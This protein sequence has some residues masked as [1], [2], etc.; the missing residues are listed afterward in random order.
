MLNLIIQILILLFLKMSNSWIEK[1]RPKHLKNIIGQNNIIST[2]KNMI[3]NNYS[4]TNLLFYG[5]PGTG[6]TTTIL[7]LCYE[8]FGPINF[9]NRVLEL[10]AS[11]ERGIGVVRDSILRF[12]K[13]SLSSPDPNYPSP[14]IKLIILDEADAMTYDAQSALR[15]IMEDYLETTRFCIICNYIE[16]II[17][18]I[19]SRCMFFN[20]VP[21]DNKLIIRHLKKIAEKEKLKL[22]D[23]D[24]ENI[25]KSYNGD[26]R[27]A[28]SS[29][30]QLKYIDD[31]DLEDEIME[32]FNIEFYDN[33]YKKMQNMDMENKIKYFENNAFDKNK[34]RDYLIMKFSDNQKIVKH[35]IKYNNVFDY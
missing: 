34:Y 3:K 4:I 16:K 24:I 19:V 35:L 7:S 28:I 2:I 30:Q 33:I 17:K 6:K 22:N 12:A 21:L 29:L 15:K 8:L 18:P 23:E 32:K 14:P 9:K 5:M 26:L 27:Q 11:D 31:E 10:N 20:F 1:Y 25:Y 13:T